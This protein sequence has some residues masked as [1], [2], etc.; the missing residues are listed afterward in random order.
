MQ[1]LPAI[2]QLKF[3]DVILCI[4]LQCYTAHSLLDTLARTWLITLPTIV[5]ILYYMIHVPQ[6][7]IQSLKETKLYAK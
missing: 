7:F 1:T 2:N 4:V 6:R 3:Q 5:T